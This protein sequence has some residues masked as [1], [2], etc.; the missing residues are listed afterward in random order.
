[1]P[2]GSSI[3]DVQAK[4]YFLPPPS[5]LSNIFLP[6]HIAQKNVRKATYFAIRTAVDDDGGG[7]LRSLKRKIFAQNCQ[8]WTYCLGATAPPRI[9]VRGRQLLV[10]PC[11]PIGQDI[12]NALDRTSLMLF[13]SPAMTTNM[14]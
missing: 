11:P 14:S 2:K 7:C 12:F 10:D 1:M 5:S 9:P 4:T 6:S 8:R 3:N 13:S